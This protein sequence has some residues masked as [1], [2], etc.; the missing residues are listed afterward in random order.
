[1]YKGIL[2]RMTQAKALHEDVTVPHDG[3]IHD[4]LKIK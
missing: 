4:L 3:E 2:M 1:M